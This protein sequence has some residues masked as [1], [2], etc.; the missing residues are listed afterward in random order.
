MHYRFTFI[1]SLFGGNQQAW[2]EAVEK[3]DQSPTYEEA[4]SMLKNEFA[5]K[6]MWDKEEDNVAILF[7]YVERKF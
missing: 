7:N 1:N 4:I 3:I 5:E 6:F 2:A